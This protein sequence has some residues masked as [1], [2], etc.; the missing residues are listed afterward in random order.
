[1]GRRLGLSLAIRTAPPIGDLGLIDLVAHVV[2]RRETGSGADG[3]VDVDDTAADPA[4]QMVMVVADTGLEA[5][6]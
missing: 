3:A 6:R 5:S 4:D 1:M 2:G